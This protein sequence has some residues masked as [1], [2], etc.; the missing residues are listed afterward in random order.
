MNLIN[1]NI[2]IVHI[3]KIRKFT[4]RVQ[5]VGVIFENEGE[6]GEFHPTPN[7]NDNSNYFNIE[8]VDLSHSKNVKRKGM[9]GLLSKYNDYF[10][11][12]N[13]K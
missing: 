4:P 9:L 7:T 3:N 10:F 5:A 12:L 1:G 8:E 6:L 2:R 13:Y 11:F